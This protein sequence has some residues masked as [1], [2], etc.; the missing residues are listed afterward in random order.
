M[1]CEAFSTVLNCICIGV[2]RWKDCYFFFSFAVFFFFSLHLEGFLLTSPSV[3]G[4][5][6][7]KLNPLLLW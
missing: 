2:K 6:H 5:F 1:K 7:T 3:N 4:T